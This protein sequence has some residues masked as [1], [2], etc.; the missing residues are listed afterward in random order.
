MTSFSE[1]RQRLLHPYYM[2]HLIYGGYYVI[3][4]LNQLIKGQS[5]NF[6]VGNFKSLA[7]SQ[8]KDFK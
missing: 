2:L 3:T 7:K 6:E 8:I 1:L 4:R 5:I